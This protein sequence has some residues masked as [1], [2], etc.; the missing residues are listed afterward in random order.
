MAH[1]IKYILKVILT[2]G[3]HFNN[4]GMHSDSPRR[5]QLPMAVS[6]E[7]VRRGWEKAERTS[8]EYC[9]SDPSKTRHSA[10]LRAS[11]V[12]LLQC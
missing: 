3:M 10:E 11:L 5:S 7:Y 9:P 8:V 4:K 2:C 6:Y 12:R 1:Y